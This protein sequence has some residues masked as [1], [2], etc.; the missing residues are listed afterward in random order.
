MS[1]VWFSEEATAGS[2]SYRLQNSEIEKTLTSNPVLVETLD[3]TLWE[4]TTYFENGAP[5]IP[6]RHAIRIQDLEPSKVY[7]YKV[8]Q[9]SSSFGSIFHTAPEGNCPIRFIVYGDS[10]TEPE[11]TGK[12]VDWPD[13][14]SDSDR[15]YLVDQTTGYRNNLSLIQS[16]QPDLV[17]I[18]G[19]LVESGGEQ[20]DWDE[21]WLHNTD[22]DSTKSIAGSIPV[23]PALGNHDYYAGPYQ[24]KYDQP[25]S[26]RAVN[27]YLT[28]FEVPE[29]HSPV[30]EEEGRYYAF[31][32][33]PA[34]FIVLDV[35][36]NDTNLSS[37]DTN[38]LL[39]GPRDS[40]GGYAPGFEMNSRQ[41][42]WMVNRLIEAQLN[43]LFTFVITHHAPYSVGPHG[44]PPGEE[45]GQDTH[46]GI[47]VRTL[48]PVFMQYGVDAVISGHDEMWERSEISGEEI[49]PNGMGR[50]HILHFYD[51]GIG[52]DGLRGPF[53][54]LVNPHQKFLAHTHSPE[55]WEDTILVSGGKHYGHLEVDISELDSI[56]WQ[57]VLK[58]V[59]VL[60]VI[61]SLSDEYTDYDRRTYDDEVILLQDFG[62]IA[63]PVEITSRSDE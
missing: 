35:C 60:P 21:F 63:V 28:Y 55:I 33:G 15:V 36:N 3:Y 42:E 17:F 57:A 47:P 9:G 54:S 46:S 56:T 52:G 44:Q 31:D 26:E 58:P 48:T 22:A 30:V 62:D 5:S 27:K 39:K 51:V 6:Y 18:A 37:F 53:D 40:A 61:D 24:G 16:R 43:R 29:N 12:F 32:Y 4:D 50:E 25:F 59:Y 10:E 2:L 11:S 1:V 8:I 41:Y 38:I 34:S 7:E 23:M 13:P 19:D 20:R 14:T 45:E 49:S